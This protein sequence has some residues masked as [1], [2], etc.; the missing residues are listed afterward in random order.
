MLSLLLRKAQIVVTGRTFLVDVSLSIPELAFY[1]LKN[2]CGLFGKLDEFQ[3]FLLSF[4]N[5]F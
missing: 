4:V 1:Q 2:L 3:V 5:V